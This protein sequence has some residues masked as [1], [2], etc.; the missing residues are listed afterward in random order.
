MPEYG[1][2]DIARIGSSKA[3]LAELADSGIFR[4]ED[5]PDDLELSAIQQNQVDA[6]L[7][8]RV[9]I[10]KNNIADELAKMAFPL[11]FLDYETCPAAIPRFDGFSPYQQIPF[12]YSLHVLN[13][14]NATLRH[15]EFLST[16]PDD[17]SAAL[18]ASLERHIG[19]IGSVIVWNKKFECGINDE[20][21]ERIPAA[22]SFLASLN[23]RVYD[24]M[25]IFQKQHYVHKDFKGGVSIK[26]V[27]PV[28]APELSYAD[29]TIKEGGTASQTWDKIATG[30]IPQDE[31]D[32]LARDLKL[33]CERDTYAMYVI[34]KHLHDLVSS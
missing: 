6:Y 5:L 4:L 24:L 33:Y 31:K 9:L 3:K 13:Q 27:L 20:M 14:P 25:D 8:D 29:L 28:V 12:Q 10:H 18:A 26:D 32:T 21:G 1:V 17:P 16:T 7:R 11:Y 34:W 30:Q 22:K 19:N 2:H 15:L 23:A